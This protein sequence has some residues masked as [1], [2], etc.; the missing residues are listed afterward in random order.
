MTLSHHYPDRMAA[1]NATV[2]LFLPHLDVSGG[3][4]V[5]CR[6]LLCAL[7]AVPSRYSYRVLV[8]DEPRA[9]FP[10]TGA[11]PFDRSIVD[12]DRVLFAAVSVPAAIDLARPLDAIL[13]PALD[14]VDL[15]YCSYYTGLVWPPVPQIV[16]FH[17]AGFLEYPSGFGGT[18]EIRTATLAQ[19]SESIAMIH[20]ISGDARGRICAR[21]PWP[22]ERAA[23]VWHALPDSPIEIARAMASPAGIDPRPY[24]LLPVGAATGFNRVRKNV[25]TAVRAFRMSGLAEHALVIAGTAAITENVLAELLPAEEAG[26]LSDGVWRSI[27]DRIRI[28][29]TLSRGELLAGMRHATAV[30]YPSRYEGFGLPVIEAMALGVSVIATRATSLPEIVGDAGLLIDPD[31]VAGFA[32]AMHTL[33]TDAVV[34]DRLIAA[35]TARLPLFTTERLGREMVNLFQDVMK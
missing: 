1:S 28:F 12:P 35:G 24:F 2:G 16:T 22:I 23:V 7:N 33:A 27:D 3:L 34:R 15:I 17:D 8:P 31:D 21:L 32:V 14:G 11:E 29:P 5:H 25:P 13:G 19:L 10:M 20:C 30:V 9:L 26:T 18:A 6:M 4:G